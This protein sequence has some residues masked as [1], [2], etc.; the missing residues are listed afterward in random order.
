MWSTILRSL[1]IGSVDGAVR[2][3]R[4]LNRMIR[5]PEN[6][7]LRGRVVVSKKRVET[8]AS[9]WHKVAHAR[10][11]IAPAQLDIVLPLDKVGIRSVGTGIVV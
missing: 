3:L 7:D 11:M 1:D 4:L 10:E 5:N 8:Q 2:I 6:E 9:I